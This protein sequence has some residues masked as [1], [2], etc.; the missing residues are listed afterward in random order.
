MNSWLLRQLEWQ[1]TLAS[2]TSV[3]ARLKLAQPR[4]R[5]RR[6]HWFV[7]VWNSQVQLDR[8]L[9]CRRAKTQ[10]VTW[11]WKVDKKNYSI[12]LKRGRKTNN[13]QST[14]GI[15]GIPPDCFRSACDVSRRG[16]VPKVWP[17][18]PR[19]RTNPEQTQRKLSH[20]DITF[21]FSPQK[22]LSVCFVSVLLV[23]FSLFP[24][25]Y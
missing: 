11:E 4:A 8:T 25:M 2:R 18:G 7:S 20:D 12:V 6:R 21:W 14:K 3:N 1:L 15:S 24:K 23:Y 19:S 17:A 22:S 5:L 16:V 13:R 10:C 9:C